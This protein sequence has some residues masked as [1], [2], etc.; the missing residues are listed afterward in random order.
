MTIFFYLLKP[1]K[2]QV[3]KLP[4]CAVE[5]GLAWQHQ[6]RSS[7]PLAVSGNAKKSGPG[8]K[9]KESRA[10]CFLLWVCNVSTKLTWNYVSQNSLL[11]FG[12]AL[13]ARIILSETGGQK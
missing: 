2:Q 5:R 13:A 1:W 3:G 11:D 4:V 12:L 6:E 8:F 10:V 7:V 9:P